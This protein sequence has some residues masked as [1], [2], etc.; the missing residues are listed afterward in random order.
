VDCMAV[1]ACRT[2]VGM[3]RVVDMLVVVAVDVWAAGAVE[4][5]AVGPVEEKV[6]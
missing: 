6:V 1:E 4:V 3:G 5:I 2:V